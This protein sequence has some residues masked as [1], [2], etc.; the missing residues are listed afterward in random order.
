MKVNE[1][2]DELKNMPKD[3]EVWH[4]WDGEARTIINHVWVSMDGK[5][6]I[7]ADDNEACYSNNTRPKNSPKSSKNLFWNTPIRKNT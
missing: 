1:L 7:T 5:R 6:V 4:L 3:L 2:I